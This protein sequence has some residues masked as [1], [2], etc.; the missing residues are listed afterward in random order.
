MVVVPSGDLLLATGDLVLKNIN[1]KTGKQTNSIY[2]VYDQIITAVHLTEKNEH[3]IGSRSKGIRYAPDGSKV[4]IVMNLEGEIHMIWEFDKGNNPLFTHT[5]YIT[6]NS[7]GNV[8]VVDWFPTKAMVEL[9]SYHQ[10]EAS[11]IPMMVSPI[12]R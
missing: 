2:S 6:S 4:L 11:S 9:S 1:P 10:L 3:I 8:A 12:T 7:K 5:R